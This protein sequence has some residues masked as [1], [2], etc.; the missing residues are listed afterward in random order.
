[1]SFKFV[2]WKEEY[3][4]GHPE[5]DRHHQTMLEIINTL[6]E[7]AAAGAS[8]EEL[9]RAIHDVQAYAEYHF[10]EEEASLQ[11]VGYLRIENQKSAHQAFVSEFPQPLRDVVD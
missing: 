2:V 5:L 6:Y 9:S 11:E 3:S 10:K 4:V 8:D 1:M 7:T